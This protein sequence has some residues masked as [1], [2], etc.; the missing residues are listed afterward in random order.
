MKIKKEVLVLTIMVL[1]LLSACTAPLVGITPTPGDKSAEATPVIDNT[2]T[3]IPTQEPTPTPQVE[4]TPTETQPPVSGWVAF[5]GMD[6]NVELVERSSGETRQITSDAV[7]FTSDDSNIPVRY[8]CLQWSSD[9]NY[10]SYMREEVVPTENNAYD[11]NYTFLL[12]DL[13]V[14]SS[15]VIIPDQNVLGY[16]WQPGTHSIAYGLPV[17]LD[18]WI[19][20]TSVRAESAHGIQLMDVDTG[21]THELV[22]PE[23]GYTLGMPRWSP[24]G[25]FLSFDEIQYMEG[26]GIISY[27]DMMKNEYVSREDQILGSYDWSPDGEQLAYDKIDYRAQGGERIW[28]SP[29]DDGQETAISPAY[30][31][32]AYAFSPAF[33]PDGEKIAFLVNHSG[34]DVENYVFNVMVMDATGSTP[35]DYGIFEQVWQLHWTSDGNFLIFSAGPT[36]QKLVIEVNLAENSYRQL[37]QGSEAMPQP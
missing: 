8:C 27:F 13:P 21:E 24:D 14:G 3:D 22:P 6:G 20:R 33:S 17:E 5:I 32:P 11:S 9:G 34:L 29:R 2:A 18:Y 37:A 7:P 16:E 30:E 4:A 25:R 23:R 28:L 31:P 36:D 10:L 35:V 12:Y 15:R 26:R 1:G 19:S